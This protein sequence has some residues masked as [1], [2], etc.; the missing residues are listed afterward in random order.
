MVTPSNTNYQETST[1]DLS[2]YFTN[3]RPE[4]LKLIPISA[5]RVLEIGCSAGQLGF[6]IKARQQ[7]HVT[8][9]DI[10]PA[11]VA[12]AATVIDQAIATDLEQFDF[13]WDD[14]SFDC[15]VAGDILEHLKDPWKVISQARR[16]LSAEGV[17]V[18]SIPNVSNLEILYQLSEGTWNYV[19]AGL[20]D[21]THL[22]F[23][24]RT[25]FLDA[26]NAV[27]FVVKNIEPILSKQYFDLP[28]EVR[29]NGG[30][31]SVGSLAINFRNGTHLLD[32]FTYQ[33]LFV[34]G[35]P[36]KLA[37]E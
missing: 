26:L 10:S 37:K 23:F 1:S 31:V 15:I 8:G 21:R 9:V 11:A 7:A 3:S 29:S 4:L 19:D 17:L 6:A 20:L 34:V 22:R 24:T 33:W 32:I 28:D 18:V 16:L 5:R 25:T 13:P 30:N 14:E 35:P 2:P 27:G 36:V 12:V